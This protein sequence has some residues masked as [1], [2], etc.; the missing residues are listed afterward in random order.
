MDQHPELHSRRTL[1]LPGSGRGRGQSRAIRVCGWLTRAMR[2]TLFIDSIEDMSA[3]VQ[4]Q[5]AEALD[6]LPDP[7]GLNPFGDVRIHRLNVLRVE[8]P[9]VQGRDLD[10]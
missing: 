4:G 1:E 5:L 7:D 3:G 10:A 9:P 8:Y 6:H 2:G